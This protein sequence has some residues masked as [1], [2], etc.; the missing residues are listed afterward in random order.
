MHQKDLVKQLWQ[1]AGLYQ[2]RDAKLQEFL[3]RIDDPR[4]CWPE[5]VDACRR[6]YPEYIKQLVDPLVNAGDKL[7][8]LNLIHA[9]DVQK[10]TEVELLRSY[11]KRSDPQADEIELRAVAI[12]GIDALNAEIK[13]KKN[14]PPAL[15]EIF[16]PVRAVREPPK[17]RARK[18]TVKPAPP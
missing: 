12:K 5:L 17:P 6:N 16:N 18:R 11:V 1:A 8:R 7:L 4:E 9:A 3:R 2:S 15:Q 10:E 13:R 14:L